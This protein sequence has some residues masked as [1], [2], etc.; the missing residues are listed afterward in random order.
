MDLSGLNH[1]IAEHNRLSSKLTPSKQEV[2]RMDFLMSAAAA[3]KAGAT[4]QEFTERNLNEYERANGLD[5]SRFK[6]SGIAASQEAEARGWQ[7]F[8]RK[9]PRPGQVTQEFRD[10]TEGAASAIG[11]IGTYTSLGYFVPTGFYDGLFAALGAHDFLFD[12]N[13]VTFMRTSTGAPIPVP[14]AGDVQNVATLTSEAGSQSSVDFYSTNHVTLGSY[15]FSSPRFVASLE[16]VDDL[17]G[18]LSVLNLF[19]RFAADRLARGIGKYLVNG[20]GSS[21]PTGLYQALTNINAPII[22][23]QGAS[24]NTGGAETSSNSLGTVDFANAFEALN[25]SYLA[26][27][28]VAW[29]MNL[30]TLGKLMTMLDKMGRPIINF[31]NGARTI[32]GIPIRI[33]PSMEDISPSQTPVVLGDWSYFCTRFCYDDTTGV[34]VYREGVGLAE[35][36]NLGLRVFARADSNILYTDQSS[37]CPFV[38][39]RNNS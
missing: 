16:S 28:K 37:P 39:I 23:A 27:D 7:E 30:K 5:V 22:N 34:A 20:T 26:S 11:R 25:S 14:V 32:L 1:V 18:T 3:I 29:A 2:R 33:C 12:E 21:Q 15:S 35:Q 36:G 24:G 17:Q 8:I 19:K 9:S 10:M 13:S 31:V 4:L 6:K 38:A